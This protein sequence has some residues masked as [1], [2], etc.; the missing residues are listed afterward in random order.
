ME[1]NPIR[2]LSRL[3]YSTVSMGTTR[4]G[5]THPP[6]TIVDHD[7][8]HPFPWIMQTEQGW[9]GNTIFIADLFNNTKL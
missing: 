9:D 7:A 6:V 2:A 5:T 3:N 1:T 8:L 4:K